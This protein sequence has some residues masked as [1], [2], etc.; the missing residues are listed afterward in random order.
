MSGAPTPHDPTTNNPPDDADPLIDRLREKYE[1]LADEQADLELSASKLPK[2]VK[3]D[4]DV[5]AVNAWVKAARE[6]AR[7]AE[8]ARK[9]EKDHFLRQG[10]K[11]DG[12]FKRELSDPVLDRARA[13]EARN[14]PYLTAKAAA[15][16]ARKEAEAAAIRQAQEDAAKREREAREAEETARR[17]A[18]AAAK[19]IREAADEETRAAAAEELRQK[20]AAAATERKAAEQAQTDQASA[21]RQAGARERAAD[22]GATHLS[23]TGA[24][25]QGSATIRKTWVHRIDDGPALWSSLGPLGGFIA[26]DAVEAALRRAAKA[27][28]R[29]TVPGVSYSEDITSRVR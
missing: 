21:E 24:A 18:E 22:K 16:K 12:F 29:P 3:T 27:D 28:E 19:K 14:T 13:I 26:A 5:I 11:V 17:E 7:K 4:A 1:A 23:R 8:A 2:E 6:L 20:E 9:D 10:Q 25:G 15:E